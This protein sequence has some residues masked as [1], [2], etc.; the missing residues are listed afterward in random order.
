[1][2]CG[3]GAGA[4]RARERKK[5][6]KIGRRAG[7]GGSAAPARIPLRSH[8]HDL[9][10]P[11]DVRGR[12]CGKGLRR[13]AVLFLSSSTEPCTEKEESKK[14]TRTCLSRRSSANRAFRE[15]CSTDRRTVDA[16]WARPMSPAGSVTYAR[17]AASESIFL[18]LFF[19]WCVS[20]FFEWC[21]PNVA[22][23]RAGWPQAG[24]R[25]ARAT[26]W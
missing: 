3:R 1:V 2:R 9:A 21:R 22:L 12:A 24:G 16:A 15:A 7:G 5:D 11:G 13:R 4:R 20:L 25:G 8:H 18:F 23:G 10:L 26:V 14:K 19:W 17:S 6:N